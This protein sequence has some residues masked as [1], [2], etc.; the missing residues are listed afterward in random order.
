MKFLAQAIYQHTLKTQSRLCFRILLHLRK[1]LLRFCD[2]VI[3]AT[4]RGLRLTMPFSHTIFIN[5]KLYPHYDMR[6]QAIAQYICAKDGRLAMIDVGANI[7][8]TV[9]LSLSDQASNASYLLIEG[10]RSY[11]DLIYTNLSHNLRSLHK[12]PSPDSYAIYTTNSALDSTGGGGDH[13]LF[14]IYT[15]FLGQSDSCEKY[16]M[17]LQDGSGKLVASSTSSSITTLDHII[18]QT[19]FTPNFIKIDTDGF[20]F[21][22]LRGARATISAFMPNLYFEWS[23]SHLLEQGESPTSIFPMLRDLGYEKLV[24]FDN[25][26]DLLCVLDST[27][28][29]NLSLLMGYTN[30]SKQIHYY[31]V[32]AIHRASSFCLQEYLRIYASGA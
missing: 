9:V 31:D 1:F 22:V 21:K 15:T 20:D 18:Q 27:D 6:L 19:N 23:L 10:E 28:R 29:L 4:F 26:G 7:G 16:A 24:I 8:D 32:L 13:K 25:F 5:Q 11:A 17:S 30:T 14:Y 12:L 2:P 3:T